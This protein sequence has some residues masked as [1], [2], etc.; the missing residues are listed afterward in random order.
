VL[1]IKCLFF[2]HFLPCLTP[3]FPQNSKFPRIYTSTNETTKNTG[4]GHD[5]EL[6]GKQNNNMQAGEIPDA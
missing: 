3:I 1:K 4:T 6:Y 5:T 2:F